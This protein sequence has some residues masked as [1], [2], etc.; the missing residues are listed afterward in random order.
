MSAVVKVGRG[1]GPSVRR[2]F[3]ITLLDRVFDLYASSEDVLA[4]SAAGSPS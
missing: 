1:A 4:T 3:E 2:I